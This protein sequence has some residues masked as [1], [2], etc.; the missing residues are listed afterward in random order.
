MNIRRC[1]LAICGM[2][3]ACSGA[4]G[5]FSN[6][7][8][9]TLVEDPPHPNFS[10]QITSSTAILTAGNGAVPIGVDIGLKSI[11]GN[12]PATSTAGYAFSPNSDFTLAIDY[13]IAFSGTPAGVLG[14][15]FGIGEDANGQNSAGI[16]ML[17]SGGSPLFNYAAVS[18]INDVNQNNV[19][20]PLNASLNG[21]LFISYLASS[22]DVLVGAATT[23][24]AANAT[25]TATLAGIQ[26]QWNNSDLIASFFLRSDLTG[27]QGG[28]TA[29][30]T[31][32]NLRVLAGQPTAVPEPTSAA[33]LLVVAAACS[34]RRS[35]K[36][37]T[38]GCPASNAASNR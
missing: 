22:G 12:T 19:V 37:L 36:N 18:R 4:R 33:V 8:D 29:T 15:G 32:S 35:R 3:L 13:A 34:M 23:P 7:N 1:L 38:R 27:W 20:V 10:A 26:N 31:F 21:S 16:A 6:F 30:A 5:D 11:T 17:T 2:L 14:I 25:A 28:G 9:W 24:G